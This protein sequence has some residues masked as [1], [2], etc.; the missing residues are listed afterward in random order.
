[1]SWQRYGALP[2]WAG[3]GKAIYHLLS[4]RVESLDEFP[5]ALLAWAKAEKPQWLKPP[6][7]LEEVRALQRGEAGEAWAK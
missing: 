7:S 6:A 1:M 3:D 5:P 4:W 2:A